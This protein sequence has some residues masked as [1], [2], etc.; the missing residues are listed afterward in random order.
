[1]PKQG[2]DLTAPEDGATPL[3]EAARCGLLVPRRF[4]G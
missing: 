4:T 2:E 1:M 3:G